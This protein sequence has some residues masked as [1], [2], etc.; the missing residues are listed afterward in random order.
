MRATAVNYSELIFPLVVLLFATFS[1]II[2]TEFKYVTIV[3]TCLGLILATLRF[4]SISGSICVASSC[5]VTNVSGLFPSIEPRRD[6]FLPAGTLFRDSA[7]EQGG[8]RK[9][10]EARKKSSDNIT[11]E[12]RGTAPAAPI[13]PPASK[14][15][16]PF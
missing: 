5:I 3:S 9:S 1:D 16:G 10:E 8:D 7:D 4:L 14:R 2:G 6:A 11:L 13:S 15:E 12:D